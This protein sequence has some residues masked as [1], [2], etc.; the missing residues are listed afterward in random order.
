MENQSTN[1]ESENLD[2]HVALCSE[3]YKT[4]EDK[5]NKLEERS[6]HIEEMVGD[7]K[8]N[9]IDLK[10]HIYKESQDRNLREAD[11]EHD[12]SALLSNILTYIV[13]AFV[14]VATTMLIY[15]FERIDRQN[16]TQQP[17]PQNHSNKSKEIVIPE[18]HIKPLAE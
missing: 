11:K 10:D 16:E 3:R 15:N 14:S 18:N 13:V 9:L 12:K 17:Y 7:L 6:N 8:D 1:I 2:V 4:L 5:L